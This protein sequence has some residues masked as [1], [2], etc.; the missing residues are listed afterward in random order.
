MLAFKED[1]KHVGLVLA[2][3]YCCLITEYIFSSGSWF[4]DRVRKKL[5]PNCLQISQIAKT[6]LILFIHPSLYGGVH[7]VE[8]SFSE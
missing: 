8:P 2:I 6:P 1:W 3:P 4:H 5:K 7:F